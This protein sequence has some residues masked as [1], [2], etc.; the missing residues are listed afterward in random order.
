MPKS[1]HFGWLIALATGIALSLL[2]ACPGPNKVD[3]KKSETRLDLA[4]DFLSKGELEA[5][6]QEA[7]KAASYNPKSEQAEYLL[8]MVAYLRAVKVFQLL[9]SEDCLTGVDA[10]ALRQDFDRDLV[11][12]DQHFAKA[13]QLSPDYAEA[14]AN[15][16]VVATQMGEFD[17]AIEHL[18]EALGNPARLQNVGVTRSNLGWAYFRKGDLV[19]AAKHLRQ[20]LQFQPKMCLA[21]YR[22]GRVY[23]ARKEWEKAGEKFQEVIAQSCPIQEAYLFSM[24]TL[25]EQGKPE[26]A[27]KLVEQC[28][29]L[30]PKSCV[31]AQCRS[32]VP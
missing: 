12:A 10:D 14:R 25:V 29:A 2:A 18:T 21:S 16:G 23:F 7:H 15:R 24:K 3:R 17:T 4:K 1:Q 20:A 28:V 5:A 9:E 19:N 26:D 8:G 32:I 13:L 6:E 22:L 30:A 27:E 31:A 11:V